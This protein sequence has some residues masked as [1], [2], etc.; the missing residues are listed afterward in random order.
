MELEYAFAALFWPEL[1][2]YQGGVFLA[3]RFNVETFQHWLNA[4]DGNLTEVE[5]MLNH[6]YVAELF[7]NA[8]TDDVVPVHVY[9]RFAESLA[10]CWQAAAHAQFPALPINVKWSPGN[11]D[12]DFEVTLSV[13]RPNI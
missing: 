8:V 5:A 10:N 7:M 13:T 9:E 2:E 12:G 11:Q 6:V 3:E 1:L 4:L